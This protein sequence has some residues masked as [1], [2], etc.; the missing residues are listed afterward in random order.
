[1]FSGDVDDTFPCNG[2]EGSPAGRRKGAACDNQFQ[3]VMKLER[4]PKETSK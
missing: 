4:E 2:D 3:V 1:M